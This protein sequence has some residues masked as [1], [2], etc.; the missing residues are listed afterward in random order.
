MGQVVYLMLV[1]GQLVML[2]M[3]KIKSYFRICIVIC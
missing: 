2:E 1:V 3:S